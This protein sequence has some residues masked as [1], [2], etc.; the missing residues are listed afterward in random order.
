MKMRLNRD[1]CAQAFLDQRPNPASAMAAVPKRYSLFQR[2]VRLVQTS[3]R[4]L[5]RYCMQRMPGLP[6]PPEIEAELK[7]PTFV[8]LWEFTL[9]DHGRNA[10]DAWREYVASFDDPADLDLEASKAEIKQAALKLRGQVEGT[11]DKNLE[12]LADQLQ[13]T[14]VLDNLSHV[15]ATT[16]TNVTFIKDELK[17]AT[18]QI[19]P[20]AMLQNVQSTV[21]QH[22]S[23][24]DVASTLASNI[25]E[26]VD[27]AKTGRDAALELKQQDM[28]VLK[29]EANSWFADKLMVGQSV[30]VAFINGY[31]E[32]K[33]L[34][35]EREDAAL[36]TLAKQ[37]AEDQKAV[38]KQ[39]FDQF[40]AA[41]RE[42]QQ[43][44]QANAEATT[45]KAE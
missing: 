6:N 35:M 13:G 40:V 28:D 31:K 32:G 20:E 22:R 17:Q 41:Q 25:D 37:V 26:L 33:Q 3:I 27:L 44:E 19:D 24:K 14:Q 42:K 8:D 38:L 11:A 30:L 34:E 7:N 21:E 45:K 12:F 29:G 18:D 39:Q 9:A 2:S 16:Q 43:H 15:R 4:R 10:R 5:D 36:I 1:H 23:K